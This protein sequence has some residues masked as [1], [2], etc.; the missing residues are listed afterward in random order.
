MPLKEAPHGAAYARLIVMEPTFTN[1]ALVALTLLSAT[2]AVVATLAL[3]A[4]L[5]GRKTQGR[6]QAA[7]VLAVALGTLGLLI[8]R[9][10][11]VPG[12]I[13]LHAHV[14]GLLLI[15]FFAGVGAFVFGNPP[16]PD[17]RGPVCFAIDDLAVVVGGVCLG[18]DLQTVSFGF[19]LACVAGGAFGVCLFGHP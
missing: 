18:V 9:W 15:V 19:S 12:W 4:A 3:K 17:G 7:L 8:L 6:L 14:D 11:Q 13:L 16:A 10:Q 2:S 1:L 5:A